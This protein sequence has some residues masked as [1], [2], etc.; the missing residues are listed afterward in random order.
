MNDLLAI[1]TDPDLGAVTFEYLRIAE[2]VDSKGRAVFSEEK[3]SAV[4]NIQPTPGKERELLPEGERDKESIVIFTP[5]P[6]RADSSDGK[7]ADLVLF[8]KS[9]YR[10]L[11]V[12][13]WGY[14]CAYTKA[15]AVLVGDDDAR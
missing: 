12:E 9:R 7:K 6:L 11:L 2:K 13:N 5:A 4:G 3:F 8:T 14:L 10:V 1:V 15:T